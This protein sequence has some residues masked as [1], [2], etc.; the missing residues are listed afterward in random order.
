MSLIARNKLCFIDGTLLQL[1]STSK[2][3]QKWIRNDYMVMTWILNSIE[4]SIA[5]NFLFVVSSRQL[6]LEITE[7]YG[8]TNVPQNFQLH[9]SIALL[10]QDNHSIAE[11]YG[12]LKRSWDEL[13]ALEGLPDCTCGAISKCSC[14]ILK[15]IF[16]ADQRLKLIQFLAGLNDSY[17]QVKTNI[18]ST[19]PLPPVNKVYY[20]L[21]Q[22]E[23]QLQ[24]RNPTF[25]PSSESSAFYAGKNTSK[26]SY[27]ALSGKKDFKKMKFDKSERFCEHCKVKGHTIDTCFK[28]VGY[29][30]W[31]TS[32][33]NKGKMAAN[34]LITDSSSGI[35]GNSPLEVSSSP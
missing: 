34:V 12:K 4:K 32:L 11:H 13:N 19:D 2:D 26:P 30:E 35:L 27:H 8:S 5:E 1:E 3:F 20:T 14:G 18:L 9:R 31:Y 17:D 23:K 15:K 16:D 28:L 25:F 7:R 24:L 29:P 22:V 10:Q 6:W 33:K 21:Q